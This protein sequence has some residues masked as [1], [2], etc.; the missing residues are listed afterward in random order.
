MRFFTWARAAVFCCALLCFLVVGVSGALASSVS[1]CVPSTGGK[2]VTSGACSVSGTTVKLPASSTDQQTL[3]SILPHIKFS[4]AGVG[5]KPTITFTGANVQIVDGAGST[6]TVNGT[7]N[8]V[9]GYDE[10]PLKVAQTGSHDLILGRDQS[11]TG[12]GELLGGFGNSA[13]GN[14]AVVLGQGNSAGGPYATVTGGFS[15][16]ANGLAVSVSGGVH[17]TAVGADTSVTGGQD[18]FSQGDYT[19]V[20][21]GYSNTASAE[22][23]SVSGGCSNFAGSG[24]PPS[25]ASA[26]TDMADFG[27]DAFTWLGGGRGGQASGF[28]AAVSGGNA[29]KASGLLASVSGGFANSASGDTSSVSGGN[30]NTASGRFSAVLGGVSNTASNNCQSIPATNT[31]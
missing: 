19:S 24:T 28:Q 30:S 26:C 4:S 25:V 2:T 3:I 22:F 7:G 9:V 12:Y 31:C 17:N 20:S 5:G 18:N 6:A 23:S 16:A 8:L 1:L 29:N 13:S 10:N 11:F 21:G 15:N 14:Y 27:T